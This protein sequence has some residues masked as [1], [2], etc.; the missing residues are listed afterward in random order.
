MSPDG[1]QALCVAPE[2]TLREALLRMDQTARGILLVLNA[3]GALRHTITDGDLRRAILKNAGDSVPVGSLSDTAPITVG[4]EADAASVLLCM[5]QHQIDHIPVLDGAGKPVDLIFR[6][7]LSQRVWLSS[8]HLGEEE[9][10]FVEDAFKTNW[11]APLGPHVDGFEGELAA[12][13][14]VA[15]AAA[16][17]SG[18]AAIH[19]GLIL[20]GVKPGDTVFCS[21][22]TFVG[23]CNPILYC[24]AKP[25]F[26]DSEPESWNMSP[27]AL[28]RA[29]D[30]ARREGR[31]PSCVILVNLYGQS[32]DMD[33][34]L[35]ICERYGVPVLED[36]AE[37]LG[38]HYKGKSSG[39]F[40]KIAVYSFNGNK[41]ITT[42]GGGMLVADDPDL[43]ARARKLSTQARE[44]APHY[45]HTEVGFN[46]RMSNVLAGIGRGQLRVLEQRVSQRRRVFERYVE[47]MADFRQI[48]WMPEPKGCHSTRWLTCFA[49]PGTDGEERSRQVMKALERHLIEARPVWKPMHL[50]PLFEGAPYFSHEPGV[51]ISADLFRR[52]ICLPS[53]SNL[54]SV[55]QDRVIDHLQHALLMMEGHHALA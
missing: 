3:S 13:V 37:S 2:L 26:I 47:A 12:H 31:M 14:G 5:D 6:R 15:H 22:L 28:E 19:L 48:Q 44:P 54:G 1:L 18:T 53:G 36:A 46:Y 16:V 25:V 20:L 40:G 24:G 29:F 8:P 32:A 9:T 27:A 41:I 55:Q 7:E 17:S 10:L 33:A 38:A 21:S 34:L 49:L 23:S 50:Q 51:D 42:S 52:G 43:I 35:P 11:I 30:W 4:E 45:E 39:A